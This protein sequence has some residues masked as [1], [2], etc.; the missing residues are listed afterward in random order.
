MKLCMDG[1]IP[2][3]MDARLAVSAACGCTVLL[4]AT[5]IPGDEVVVY[6]ACHSAFMYRTKKCVQDRYGD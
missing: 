3:C 1:D 2:S 5:P 4:V 6:A